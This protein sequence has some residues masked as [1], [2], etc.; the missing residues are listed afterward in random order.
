MKKE[1]RKLLKTLTLGGGMVTLTNLPSTWSKP[2]VESLVLPAHA[3]TSGVAENY[4]GSNELNVLAANRPENLNERFVKQGFE[5]RSL[6]DLVI[7]PAYAGDVAMNYAAIIHFAVNYT[8]TIKIGYSFNSG[9][10][11]NR[12]DTLLDKLVGV[13]HA[14]DQPP[15]ACLSGNVDTQNFT[16]LNYVDCE[17]VF[18]QVW[19]KIIDVKPNKIVGNLKFEDNS[20]REFT[21]SEGNGN[22]E[23]NCIPF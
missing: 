10:G 18:G 3:Q 20:V 8:L 1:R 17:Q 6:L 15:S 9:A 22:V 5:S 12:P 19:G 21:V 16:L 13:A 11:L 4:F 7:A 2:V 23:C 14:E